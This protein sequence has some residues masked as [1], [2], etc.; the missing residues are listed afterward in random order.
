MTRSVEIPLGQGHTPLRLRAAGAEGVAPGQRIIL[1]LRPEDLSLH[2]ARP[3]GAPNVLEG[4]VVTT[5]YLGSFLDCRVRVGSHE[6]GVQL[7]H[8]ERLSPAQKVF[9]T[10]EP[11]RGLGLTG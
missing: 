3:D 4:E 6:V 5:V 2:L 7:D 11:D 1:S 10:F 8:Y 9:L